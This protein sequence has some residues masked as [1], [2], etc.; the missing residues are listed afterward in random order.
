[1]NFLAGDWYAALA[2]GARYDLIVSNPP[3]IAPGDPH[4]AELRF[5]PVNALVAAQGGLA[6]LERIIAGARARLAPD[7]WLAVEQ[8][9]DQAVAVSALFARHGLRAQ[10]RADALGHQRVTLGQPGPFPV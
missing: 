7:G 4:L 10:A 5:E 2:P 6:C 9:Y 3:Y 8:G 1:V